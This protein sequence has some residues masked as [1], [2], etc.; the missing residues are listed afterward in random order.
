M[1]TFAVNSSFAVTKVD[2]KIYQTVLDQVLK[3]ETPP[4]FA[5]W[6]TAIPFTTILSPRVPRHTPETQFTSSFPG[7]PPILPK[8]LFEPPESSAALAGL[9]LS[10][11]SIQFDG[12]VDRAKFQNIIT[13]DVG[14]RWV[15]AVGFSKVAYDQAANNALVYVESCM[16]VLEGV[17]GGEGYWFV[18]I[19]NNWE[20]KNHAYLWQ[21]TTK[22]FWNF[23]ADNR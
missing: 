22:P 20:L 2:Q 7:L 14:P 21:G 4:K 3:R 10:A 11:D 8:R 6:D 5:V 18:R 23:D 19:K 9:D 16:T 15:L 1:L 12:I 13:H 17:C